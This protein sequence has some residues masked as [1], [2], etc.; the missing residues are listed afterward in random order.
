MA[1]CPSPDRSNGIRIG[2]RTWVRCLATFCETG[3]W[4]VL[5]SRM[6]PGAWVVQGSCRWADRRRNRRISAAAVAEPL[7]R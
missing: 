3:G 1:T 5:R 2:E 7:V 6:E 4:V